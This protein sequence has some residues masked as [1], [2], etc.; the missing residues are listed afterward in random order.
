MCGI[1]GIINLNGQPVE[2]SRLNPMMKAM[3]HRGPDDEGSFIEDN[4][5]LGFVRLSIIDLSNSRP[6]TYVI[7]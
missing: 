1:C 7:R 3:K 5:A 2:G 4:I 6:S